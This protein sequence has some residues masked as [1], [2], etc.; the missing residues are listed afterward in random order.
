MG[1]EE[2]SLMGLGTGPRCSQEWKLQCG[3]GFQKEGIGEMV[4]LTLTEH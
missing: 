3:G 4:I 1:L 2:G